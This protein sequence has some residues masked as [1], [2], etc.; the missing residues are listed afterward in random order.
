MSRK[1][2]DWQPDASWLFPPSPRDW[3]PEY[4]LV[5]F[6]LEVTT[7]IDISP[8]VNDYGGDNGGQPPFQHVPGSGV[9]FV[10]GDA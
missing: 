7:Q 1:F 8:I 6:L 4:D 3:L 9:I 2:R 5:Y 10:G